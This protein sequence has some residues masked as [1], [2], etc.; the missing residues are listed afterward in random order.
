LAV[1]TLSDEDLGL[2]LRRLGQRP[3]VGPVAGWRD[4]PGHRAGPLPPAASACSP[5]TG[6]NVRCECSCPTRPPLQNTSA[7]VYFLMG[8]RFSEDP[9]CSPDGGGA[10]AAQ[11]SPTGV[12]AP[13]IAV[14][15]RQPPTA[16]KTA[17]SRGQSEAKGR[18]LKLEARP[19][20]QAPVT[21]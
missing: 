16:A 14:S 5:S 3:A 12:C 4:A 7:A 19:R 10:A 21:R 9:S 17:Q 1:D 8:D 2:R 15:G 6:K 20:P 18:F 11:C 13:Q